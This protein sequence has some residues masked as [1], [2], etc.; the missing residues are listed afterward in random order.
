[1][2]FLPISAFQAVLGMIFGYSILWLI[3]KIFILSTK[4]EGLG[5]GDV[6]LLSCIGAYTGVVGAWISLV[7]A[8]C[9][10]LIVGIIYALATKQTASF[11]SLKI[12]FGPFLAIGAI[13][14][15]FASSFL[16]KI[17]LGI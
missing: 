8:S 12:P 3:A 14:Y 7:V 16:E 11:R 5:L 17:L 1:M 6:E 9:V 2:D 13:S 10:G 15:V 4:R